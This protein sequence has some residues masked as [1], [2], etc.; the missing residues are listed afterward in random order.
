MNNSA[1]MHGDRPCQ[2]IL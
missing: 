2:Q 1:A